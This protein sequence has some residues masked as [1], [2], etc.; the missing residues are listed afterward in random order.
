PLFLTLV[1]LVK[2]SSPGPIFFR[3]VRIGLHKKPFYIFKFRTMYVGAEKNGP[4]LSSR[5]DSRITPIGRFVRKTR[6]DEIPQ[7]FNVIKGDM[8]I[9]GPRPERQYY[10]NQIVERAPHYVHL[11]KVKPGITSWG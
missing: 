2:F 1:I 9:V 11:H 8:S 3:Q 5:T 10:I 6:L 4:Q 7:F